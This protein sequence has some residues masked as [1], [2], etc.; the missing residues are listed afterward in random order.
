[1]NMAFGRGLHFCPGAV[2]GRLEGR[3]AL[4]VLT[5]RIPSLRLDPAIELEYR[6][7]AT[8]HGPVALPLSWDTA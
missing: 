2:L 7:S 3:V 5:S 4:E 6:S 8:Q 1:V